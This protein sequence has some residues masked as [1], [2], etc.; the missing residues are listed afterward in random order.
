MPSKRSRQWHR[1][2]RAEEAAA[3]LRGWYTTPPYVDVMSG[4]ALDLSAA[5]WG[6]VRVHGET[7]NELRARLRVA[8]EQGFT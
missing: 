7:D 6:C 8:L 3:R 4:A 1:R 2:K 5:N